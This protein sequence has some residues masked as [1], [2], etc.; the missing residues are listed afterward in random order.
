MQLGGDVSFPI[1]TKNI[2][3]FASSL[4]EEISEID[5]VDARPVPVVMMWVERFYFVPT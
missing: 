5:V 2:L 4:G 1:R 3:P